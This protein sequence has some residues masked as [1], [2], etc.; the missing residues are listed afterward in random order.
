MTIAVP[1]AQYKYVGKAARTFMIGE[2]NGGDVFLTPDGITE[3][4]HQQ[5]TALTK[6]VGWK[7]LIETYM[8]QEVDMGAI[9]AQEISTV[10]NDAAQAMIAMCEKPSILKEYARYAHTNYVRR[11]IIQRA[12]EIVGELEGIKDLFPV[13]EKAVDPKES[14]EITKSKIDLS[15]AADKDFLME[16]ITDRRITVKTAAIEKLKELGLWEE[17]QEKVA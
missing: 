14:A 5:L 1:I 16:L 2:E 15:T 8:V 6:E 3:L 17:P 7:T 4:N 13:N 11:L 10:S 9:S 12:D